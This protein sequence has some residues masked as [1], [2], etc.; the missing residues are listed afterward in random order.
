MALHVGTGFEPDFR[1]GIVE[2]SRSQSR[3]Y[4]GKLKRYRVVSTNRQVQYLFMIGSRQAWIASLQAT[5]TQLSSYGVR[6]IDVLVDEDLLVP[7]QEYHYLD[8]TEDPPV[9]ISQ[10]P[11]GFV[12][13]QSTVDPNRADAS[14]WL[15][16]L[17]V[18]R[19]CRRAVSASGTRRP[20]SRAA[21]GSS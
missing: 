18:I 10:I 12:G 1:R 14:P 6:T 21:R 7:A 15:D 9:R 11:K 17:P 3:L 19:Q 4:G 5:T 16:R 2:E 20:A 13:E 8:H